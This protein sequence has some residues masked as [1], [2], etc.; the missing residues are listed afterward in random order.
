MRNRKYYSVRTGRLQ[1][2]AEL[3]LGLLREL[4]VATYSTFED[5][6]YFQ[7]RLGIYCADGYTP[8]TVGD[9]QIY[10]FRKLRRKDLFPIWPRKDDLTEDEIFDLIE[11]LFDHISEPVESSGF[12]HGWNECGHHYSEFVPGSA[13][14]DFR[15]EVNEFL[16]DYG[17]GFELSAD[18]EVLTLPG[19]SLDPLLKASLP[20]LDQANVTNRVESAVRKFRSRHASVDDRRDAIRDLTDVL[21]FLRPELKRV[22]AT[23]DENDLFNL[24]NNFGIRHHNFRQKTNYD[25][26]IWLS[27]IFY[28]YLATIHAAARLI[29]KKREEDRG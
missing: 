19:G 4:F 23:A 6:G 18:G 20:E 28:F 24:A 9:V 21:E 14:A 15:K 13:Q 8:G 5:R 10:S 12:H 29:D 25:K 22:L 2:G 1:E 27:W 7:E 11:F 26:A 3:G 16:R 17:D